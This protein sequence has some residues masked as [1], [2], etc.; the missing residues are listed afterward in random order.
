MNKRIKSKIEFAFFRLFYGAFQRVPY[1]ITERFFK[2]LFVFGGMVVG[3]RKTVALQNL[4]KVFP[5]YSKKERNAILKKMYYFMGKTIAEIYFCKYQKI[6]AKT[7]VKGF[8]HLEQ[9]VSLKKG[10]ILA[11]CHSGNWEFAGK[12]IAAKYSL[13]VIYKKLRNP[14]FDSFTNE[15][16]LKAKI[17]VIHSKKSL[18]QIFTYLKKNYII[19]ILIDQDAGKNGILT[20]F[21]GQP[22]ST[23]PGAAKIAIKTGVPIVPAIALRDGNENN[24]LVFQKMILPEEYF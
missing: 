14:Y 5:N 18:K 1:G 11:T 16:R 12:Y 2:S 4:Q 6:A 3:I 22:A 10:V 21:L 24:L 19:T 8:E 9:A 13:A 15:L 7:T 23:F 17:E 20:N